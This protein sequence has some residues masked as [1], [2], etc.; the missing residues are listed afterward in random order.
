MQW[1]ALLEVQAAS[2]YASTER[3]MDFVRDDRLDWKPATGDNWLTTGQLLHHLSDACGAPSKG[4]VTGDWGLP[5][6][7]DPRQLTPEEMLPPAES[8]PAV[9]SV[10]EAKRLLSADRALATEML[11]QVSDEDLA[12]RTVCAPWETEPRP[13]GHQLLRM[14][15]HL[16]GHRAQLFYY[17]KL[18]GVPVHTGHL[19][20]G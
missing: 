9:R 4:F 7:F 12:D 20:V 3:L 15:A 1:K 10:E 5:D 11:T 16:E 13:L 8:F 17:L 19:W 2:A 18:Q 6:G 14:I